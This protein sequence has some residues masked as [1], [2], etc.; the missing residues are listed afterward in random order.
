MWYEGVK[1]AESHADPLHRFVERVLTAMRQEVMCR[2]FSAWVTHEVSLPGSE[3]LSE[4]IP[5]QNEPWNACHLSKM[6]PSH[7]QEQQPL[8]GEVQELAEEEEA[9]PEAQ[10]EPPVAVMVAAADSFRE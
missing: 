7:A 3:P 9:E 6:V 8:A 4:A 10:A 5:R 1:A 2:E